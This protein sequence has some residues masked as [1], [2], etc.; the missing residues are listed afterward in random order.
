VIAA[1]Y[2]RKSTDQNI[3][4]EEKSVTRQV[5]PRPRLR[6]APGLGGGGGARLRTRDV[7]LE[8]TGGRAYGRPANPTGSRSVRPS[9]VMQP[10]QGTPGR[11]ARKNQP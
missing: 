4:D 10:S 7:Y 1:I 8:P 9:R 11:A 2:A 3:A 6:R 5:E